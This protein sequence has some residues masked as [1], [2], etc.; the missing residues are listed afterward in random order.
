[1]IALEISNDSF[2]YF[3]SQTDLV[4]DLTSSNRLDNSQQLRQYGSY[5]ISNNNNQIIDQG[6]KSLQQWL[7]TDDNRL[8]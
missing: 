3:V 6:R 2:Q 4:L 8:F 7:V 5:R 1:M